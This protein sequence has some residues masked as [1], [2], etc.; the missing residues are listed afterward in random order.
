[1]LKP[2]TQSSKLAS[3]IS[4]TALEP[5][6]PLSSIVHRTE[7]DCSCHFLHYILQANLKWHYYPIGLD[8]YLNL[9]LSFAFLLQSVKSIDYTRLPSNLYEQIWKTQT[10]RHGQIG[11]GGVGRA[12]IKIMILCHRYYL[13][14]YLAFKPLCLHPIGLE[15]QCIQNLGGNTAEVFSGWSN[16]QTYKIMVRVLCQTE[17]IML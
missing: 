2:A 15:S 14:M 4:T 9:R 3:L 6:H 5:D 11:H 10:K 1:V 16:L 8:I 13:T 17:K 12:V 7:Q